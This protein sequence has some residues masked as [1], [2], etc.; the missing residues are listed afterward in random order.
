MF[1][2]TCG[3]GILD[4]DLVLG[5]SP[6]FSHFDTTLTGPC[7]EFVV[8]GLASGNDV[9]ILQI[10]EIEIGNQ[11]LVFNMMDMRGG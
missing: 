4:A 3:Y 8:T 10:G 6:T 5:P 7:G 9:S 2:D 11:L 1:E